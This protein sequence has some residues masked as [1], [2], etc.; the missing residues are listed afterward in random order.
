[1]S[2]RVSREQLWS[3]IDRDASELEKHLATCPEC[4]TLAQD[5]R[6]QIGL[7]AVPLT[8]AAPP[9]PDR[10]G[11]YLIKRLIG[12]GGQALGFEAEQEDPRRP[13]ALKVL[14]DGPLAD[15]RQVGLFLREKD[16]LAH[17]H[18]SFIVTIYE[19]GRTADGRYFIAMELVD[20]KPLD[21]YVEDVG[22]SLKERIELCR[23]ICAAVQYAHEH[24]VI[25]RDLKPSNILVR[26]DGTPR[27]LDFGLARPTGG[28]LSPLITKTRTGVIEGTPRHMSPEQLQGHPGAID[29]RSDIY[30]LG[31]LF[32]EVFTGEAPFSGDSPSF[33][34][35]QILGREEPRRA[36]TLN[37]QLRGDLEEILGR[38]LEAD[39]V[40]RYPSVRAL[41]EGLQHHLEGRPIS[42]RR[43]RHTP[44]GPATV[45]EA[46]GPGS[47]NRPGGPRICRSQAGNAPLALPGRGTI[48]APA[49]LGWA[50]G[51]PERHFPTG[52]RAE[53]V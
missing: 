14:R 8:L 49:D 23:R 26:T 50:P 21:R 35:L 52:D 34:A 11:S 45:A 30:A 27:I 22:L 40:R 53:H 51:Q 18:C 2:R 12:E 32:F 47:R 38:A 1:L 37:P 7:V 44:L 43:F 33:E 16:T 48:T 15:K 39:P 42:V 10:I 20:G 6:A 13:V 28:D 31:V 36:G 3:W 25:H 17:L 29:H 46:C 9:M 41:D 24:G 5:I 19:A 4:R